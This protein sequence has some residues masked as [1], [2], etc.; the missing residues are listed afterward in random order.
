M[1]GQENEIATADGEA[2][3]LSYG[4]ILSY[5]QSWGVIIASAAIDPIWWLFVIWIPNYLVNVFK[6]D[7]A[8]ITKLGWVPF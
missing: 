5:K 4:K 6:M 8:G 7:I 2:K 3:S 1:K